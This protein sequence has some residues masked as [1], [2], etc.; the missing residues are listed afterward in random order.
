MILIT[1]LRENYPSG[2]VIKSHV[3]CHYKSHRLWTELTNSFDYLRVEITK[4]YSS[5][6]Y[7][8]QLAGIEST[9]VH[10]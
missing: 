6:S 3:S 5:Q 2:A 4:L 7:Y 1:Y 8:S 9:L 10:N